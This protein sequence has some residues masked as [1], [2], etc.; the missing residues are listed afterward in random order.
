[1]KAGDKVYCINNDSDDLFNDDYHY[2]NDYTNDNNLDTDSDYDDTYV[3]PL[4][5][6]NKKYTIYKILL[7]Y[8]D[9]NSEWVR[10]INDTTHKSNNSIYFELIEIDD[11]CFNRV[12]FLSE[13]EYRKL[14]IKH[15][16]ESR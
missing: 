2:F 10:E 9:L 3:G 15:I 5:K 6:I 16:N 4:L 14:K 12:R 8:S 7:V 13:R 11:L 1:M